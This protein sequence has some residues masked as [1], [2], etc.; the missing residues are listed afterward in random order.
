[1]Q[2]E[3][4]GHSIFSLSKILIKAWAEAGIQVKRLFILGFFCLAVG[5]SLLLFTETKIIDSAILR[6]LGP[7]CLGVF[8]LLFVFIIA[9]QTLKDEQAAEKEIKEK[10]AELKANPD[11]SQTAWDLARIKLES[12]LNRNINQVRW[13]FV[14]TIVVMLTAFGIIIYG[15]YKVYDSPANFQPSILVTLAGVMTEFIAVTFLIIYKSTMAQAKDYVNVL[16]RINA[17]GM[18]IQV[19]ETLGKDSD[20]L[21]DNSKAELAREL[22]KLYGNRN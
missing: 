21:K 18:S 20:Q 16:E 8:F 12:Y 15:I 2:I 6:I 17:V 19:L 1:M 11:D 7:A 4:F 3:F 10:E 9:N 14:W 5:V 13:I 22:L